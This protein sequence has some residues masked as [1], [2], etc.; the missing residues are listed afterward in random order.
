M[1]PLFLTET[2]DG[3][4][5]MTNETG[6]LFVCV[7]ECKERKTVNTIVS[8]ILVSFMFIMDAYLI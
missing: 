2:H 4:V 7:C 5:W 1:M 3:S 8:L 6:L